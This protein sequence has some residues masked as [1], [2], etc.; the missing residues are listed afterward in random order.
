MELVRVSTDDGSRQVIKAFDGKWLFKVDVSPDG[1]YVAY[2]LAEQKTSN[3]DVFIFDLAEDRQTPLVKH[4]ANNKLLGWTPDGQHVFFTSD[5]NGTWD[6]WLLRVQ[7][8]KPRGLPEVIKAG[9]GDVSPIGFTRS[10]SFYYNFWH[11]AWNVYTAKLDLD[12]GEVLSDPSPVRH[13]GKDGRPDWSPDG[14]YLAYLSQP[15]RNKTQIIRIRTLATGQ[16]RELKTELPH[17]GWLRW[18]PDSRHLLI[19]NFRRGSL[20]VVYR[21]D[22]QTGEHTALVRSD[23]QRIRQAELSADGKTLAYRIRGSGNANWLIVRDLETGREKELLQTG[24]MG[25]TILSP[26]SGGWALSPD[27][28]HVALS[29][30][31]GEVNKPLKPLVLKIMSVASGEARIVAGASVGE[32]AWTSNGRDLLFVKEGTELWRV[33][34]ERGEPRKLWEWKQM[35]WGPRIHPDGQRLAFFSGG[36]VSEMWVMENFLPVDVA[37]AA[38][39]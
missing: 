29:V 37:S 18:C 16:E 24:A 21:I 30:R 34:A 22:V 6:G 31:E 35:L 28:K 36:N 39:K 33:S 32:L 7:D 9:M 11:E 8:G 17:F 26:F 38:G 25:A 2:D 27:G 3:P 5:R 13:V 1:R 23:E 14:R 4:P 19:T 10:G 12:T 20:S 15:D